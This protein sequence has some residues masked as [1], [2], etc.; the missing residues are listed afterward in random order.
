[1]AGVPEARVRRYIGRSLVST[2]GDFYPALAQDDLDRLCAAYREE[3]RQRSHR[4]TSV[5]PGIPEMLDRL[6]GKKTT[7]TTKG[8]AT[9]AL[10]LELFGLRRHFDHVQGSDNGRYKPDPA[11]LLEAAEVLKVHPKDCL[12]V[13]DTIVDIEAGQ[14]AGMRTCA[15]TW[16]YGDP[17]EVQALKPDYY[18]Q[19]PS[20]LLKI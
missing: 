1:M 13:G 8:T 15:V 19:Q 3:Y 14:R 12:M 16:G 2:F 6:P 9:T 10:V 17:V 7:A 11:I 20:E 18:L 5:F 4:N